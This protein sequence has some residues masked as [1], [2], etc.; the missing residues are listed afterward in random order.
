LKSKLKNS[1]LLLQKLKSSKSEEVE[2]LEEKLVATE[3]ENTN[4]KNEIAQKTLIRENLES[5]V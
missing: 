2:S 1:F 3:E 4:L 5:Q